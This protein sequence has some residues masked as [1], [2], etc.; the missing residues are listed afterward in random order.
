MKPA[1]GLERSL[2]TVMEILYSVQLCRVS[3]VTAWVW[4]GADIRYG[5][6]VD[7]MCCL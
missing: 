3:V 7:F 6:F 2:A 1:T 5:I 4:N